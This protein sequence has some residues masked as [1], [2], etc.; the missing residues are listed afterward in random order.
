MIAAEALRAR[1]SLDAHPA[2]LS[3]LTWLVPTAAGIFAGAALFDLMPYA[4]GSVGGEALVWGSAGFG[5]TLLAALVARNAD[6]RWIGWAAGLGI[7]V[8]SI[9]E[10]VAA[11]TGFGVG[12]AAG[13]LISVG[14]VVHLV[15]ESLALFGVLSG[16]GIASRKALICCGT[17]WL[18]VMA[19]FVASQSV[20]TD[21]PPAALGGPLAFGAGAFLS[22]AGLS[23]GGRSGSTGRNILFALLGVLWVAAQHLG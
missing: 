11:G 5:L 12:L 8:H 21:L 2:L 16:I 10:G 3:K 19:G 23:W 4:L 17:P 1:P 9:L 14:L 15:P 13:I 22:L 7:W 18:L 20:L 6:R